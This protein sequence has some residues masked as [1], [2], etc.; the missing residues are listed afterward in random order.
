MN[1]SNRDEPE[2]VLA[3]VDTGVV[4]TYEVVQSYRHHSGTGWLRSRQA[5]MGPA[6]DDA[7]RDVPVPGVRTAAPWRQPTGETHSITKIIL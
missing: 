1:S 7:E 6:H 3:W 4:L 2:T 5:G